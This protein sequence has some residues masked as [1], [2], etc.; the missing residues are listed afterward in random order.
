MDN[1]CTTIVVPTG[2]QGPPGPQAPLFVSNTVFVDEL[3]G[4]NST[5]AVERRDLPF[6]TK[7]AAL[8]AAIGM[9]PSSSKRIIISV[10]NVISSL[11]IT[12]SNFIDYD[13][14]G[15]SVSVVGGA[16]AAVDDNNVACNSIIYNVNKLAGTTTNGVKIQNAG[17]NLTIHAKETTSSASAAVAISGG[18]LEIFGRITTTLALGN[19]IEKSGGNLILNDVTLIAPIGGLSLFSASPQNVLIYGVCEA[20]RTKSTNITPQVGLFVVDVN[21]I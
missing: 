1:C 13:L 8:A 17:T 18:Q 4:S 3:Y 20:N 12:L 15:G 16:V 19:S 14:N 7:T 5:G 21:V 9:S 10:D 11:P 6:F 2:E